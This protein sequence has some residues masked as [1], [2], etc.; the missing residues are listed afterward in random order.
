MLGLD[1]ILHAVRKSSREMMAKVRKSVLS[2][3]KRER[4]ERGKR[5]ILKVHRVGRQKVK[6]LCH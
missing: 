3:Y 5:Q 2:R 6:F 1:F 4:R